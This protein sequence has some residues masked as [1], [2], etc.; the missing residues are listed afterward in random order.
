MYNNKI[1]IGKDNEKPGD[2]EGLLK[3]EK[4]RRPEPEDIGDGTLEEPEDEYVWGNDHSFNKKLDKEILDERRRYVRVRYIQNIRCELIAEPPGTELAPPEKPITLTLFD[5]SMAGL[6]GVCD[7]EIKVGS[8]LV[9][10][11][12]LDQMPY[13]IKCEIIYCLK[14]SDKFRVGFKTLKGHKKFIHHLKLLVAR[15]SLTSKYGD[16]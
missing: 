16:I 7:S 10:T 3:D 6:G 4:L 8:I 5:V 1:I 12:M 15:L 14:E 11:M 9:F 13:E 2:K